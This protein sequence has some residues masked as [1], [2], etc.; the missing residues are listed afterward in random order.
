MS[1]FI[2]WDWWDVIV[3]KVNVAMNWLQ[4]II[5]VHSLSHARTACKIVAWTVFQVSWPKQDRLF[6]KHRS[7]A[8]RKL[9]PSPSH[10]GVLYLESYYRILFIPRAYVYQSM[11][12][13]HCFNDTDVEGKY[14]TKSLEIKESV[15][16]IWSIDKQ[17]L[18]RSTEGQFIGLKHQ[19][20]RRVSLAGIENCCDNYIVY[21]GRPEIV[22]GLSKIY[23]GLGEK[24]R[25]SNSQLQFVARL[26]LFASSINPQR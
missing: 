17:L 6:T 12:F 20:T 15:G 9:S 14:I 8:R 2:P 25:C 23:D 18:Q 19:N 5:Q 11:V 22:L 26:M 13:S 24:C 3:V 7:R 1:L 4:K 21:L 16:Y 10:I